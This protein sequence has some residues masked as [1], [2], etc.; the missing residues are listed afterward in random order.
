MSLNPKNKANQ[1]LGN[2]RETKTSACGYILPF[3]TADRCFWPFHS[4]KD[5]YF[6][7]DEKKSFHL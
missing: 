4:F 7:D 2:L 5:A 3:E 6:V 1:T